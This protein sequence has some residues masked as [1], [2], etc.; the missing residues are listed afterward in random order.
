MNKKNNATVLPTLLC[1]LHTLSFLSLW[2]RSRNLNKIYLNESF[3]NIG[4][5]KN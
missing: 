5:Y 4:I 1:P 2:H 3:E